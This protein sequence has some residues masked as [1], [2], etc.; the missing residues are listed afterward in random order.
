VIN[1][2]LA[3]WQD[4]TDEPLIV[5][6]V[7]FLAGYAWPILDPGLPGELT[8][9]CRWVNI[10]IWVV[11]AV[12][13]AVRLWLAEHRWRYLL[14]NWLDVITLALP[15]LRPLRV[16]RAVLALSVLG[17]HSGA[18]TRGRVVLLRGRCGGCRGFR[19]VPGCPGRRTTQP[20]GQHQ[21]L[22]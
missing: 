2:R 6:A 8:T 1:H 10:I 16:L 15:M 22:R 21:D 7:L 17:R 12:D 11:F 13:L 3:R 18:F 20:A 19:G 9:A 14:S 4:R 5:A